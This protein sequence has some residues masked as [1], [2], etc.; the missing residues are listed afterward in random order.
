MASLQSPQEAPNSS[1]IGRPIRG[2]EFS[3][4]DHEDRPLGPGQRGELCIRGYNIMKGYYKNAP[5]TKDALRDGW[6]HSGDVACLGE[7]GQ[8]HIVDRMKD[9]VLRGGFNVY[10]REVEEVLYAHPAVR[11][12]V[13]IGVPHDTLGEEVMAIVTLRPGEQISAE[14]LV[15]HCKEHVAAYKYLRI[16]EI[17]DELPKVRPARFSNGYFAADCP[18]DGEGCGA[19]IDG[20]ACPLAIPN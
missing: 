3:I 14:E 17:R 5:A 18:N 4:V 20:R 16:I 2:V 9:M 10:P 8:Y 1:G 12:A 19:P 6:F 7:D 13:V 11:E 15:R